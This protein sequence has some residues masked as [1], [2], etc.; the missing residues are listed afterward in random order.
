MQWLDGLRGDSDVERRTYTGSW[1]STGIAFPN[2]GSTH[3]PIT[4]LNSSG[5]N[6]QFIA[7]TYAIYNNSTV[8]LPDLVIFGGAYSV[9]GGYYSNTTYAGLWY[10]RCNM[11]AT[12]T[13]SICR[14]PPCQDRLRGEPW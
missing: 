5:V 10:L 8:T 13:P 11:S 2:S 7:D 3:Y 4:F 9:V 6:E 1:A 14:Q 12:A